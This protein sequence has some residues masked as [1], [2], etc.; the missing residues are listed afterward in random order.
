[1]SYK[2]K[3]E[4]NTNTRQIKSTE[5][6]GFYVD[7]PHEIWT[8]DLIHLQKPE[9][10]FKYVLNCMDTFTKKVHS[11]LLTGKNKE[12]LER[13]LLECFRFFRVKPKKIQSDQ[14]AGLLSKKM[15]EFF[16][17]NNIILYHTFAETH[18][19][20]IERFNR[21]Q[22]ENVRRMVRKAGDHLWS[23][24]IKLFEIEYNNK[25]HAFTGYKPNTAHFY[26][27]QIQ[28][29][30]QDHVNRPRNEPVKTFKL[31]EK[32]QTKRILQTFEKKSTADHWND[33]IFIIKSISFTN[34]TTY[35]LIDLNGEV[36]HGSFYPYELRKAI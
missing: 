33:E 9:E 10:N 11:V 26:K 2:T 25:K 13:A 23:P 20:I 8:I 22:K 27:D 16:D 29:K 34:P 30:F 18:N 5:R 12:E 32:V 19:P 3:D 4:T 17:K 35:K 6:R 31:G 1:M 21:T 36:I 24:Q 15:K 14:E 28:Q 7:A